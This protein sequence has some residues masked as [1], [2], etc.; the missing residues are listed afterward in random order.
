MPKQLNPQTVMEIIELTEGG[1]FS[2]KD[3][4]A[5]LDIGTEAGKSTL[6]SIIKRFKDDKIIENAGGLGWYRVLDGI[7]PEIDWQDAPGNFIDI[8][9]P[10]EIEKY[11]RMKGK[12]MM[13]VAGSPNTGKTAFLLKTVRLNMEH[14]SVY[15]WTTGEGGADELRE[16]FDGIDPDIPKPAPFSVRERFDNFAD[17][18]MPDAVNVIDYLDIDSE[19]YMVGA[20][21][22]KILN[23]LNKGVAIVGLQKPFGRELGYGGVFSIKHAYVYLS[24][25][26]GKLKIVK[27]KS[28]ADRKVNPINKQWTFK[29]D[30]V[31]NFCDIR[32]VYGE[33]DL[34]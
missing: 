4:R 29:I 9:F 7:A 33:E 5:E 21:L 12:T 18:I 25:D 17:V 3:I 32:E 14:H 27:A 6:R 15:L 26:R 11:A 28:R 22:R 16:R 23:K 20:E 19:L 34:Y 24:M 13:V 8:K 1:K 10:F 30:A 31:G 2:L